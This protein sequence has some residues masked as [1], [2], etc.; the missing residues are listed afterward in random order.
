MD[1]LLLTAVFCHSLSRG[2][3][4][5][6][7][8]V[9]ANWTVLTPN[10]APLIIAPLVNTIFFKIICIGTFFILLDRLNLN[11]KGLFNS[12]L[13]MSGHFSSRVKLFFRFLLILIPN[14][15][16]PKQ[17]H[18]QTKSIYSVIRVD[19]CLGL[20]EYISEKN[21]SDTIYS[22]RTKVINKWKYNFV[23]CDFFVRA[24]EIIFSE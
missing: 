7:F 23:N 24:N 22:S 8:H 4:L 3:L 14:V 20:Y 12:G 5:K 1:A 21:R 17:S 16:N 18:N 10:S 15:N 6:N 2:N 19:F 13:C 11:E 9:G